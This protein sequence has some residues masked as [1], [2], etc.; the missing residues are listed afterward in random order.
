MTAAPL[1][2]I[3]RGSMPRLLLGAIIGVTLLRTAI[4]VTTGLTDDEAYY[5]LWTLAPALS[6]LDHPP[7]VAWLMSAGRFL[8]GDTVLGLRLPSLLI[9]LAGP[10]LLWRTAI[11]LFDRQTAIAAVAFALVMPLLAVGGIITTPDAPSVLFWGLCAWGL[12]EMHVS[13]NANWWLAVG[14]F[15]GLGLLSKY[16][17]LFVGAGILL[18]VLVVPRN[19]AW[20]K[21]WQLWAGGVIAAICTLPVVIW[22]ARYHWASFDK[23]LGRAARGADWTLNF[24]LEMLGGYIGLASPIIAILGLIGLARL[25]QE[26][27]RSRDERALLVLSGLAPLVLYFLVHALHARVQAN[28]LAPLYPALALA[29]GY[30][31]TLS[32]SA[33]KK[34]WFVAAVATGAV[35]TGLVYLHALR[36]F[37]VLEGPRDPTSQ[38]RGWPQL[39]AEVERLRQQNGAAWIG[40]GNYATTGQLAFA[41][42]QGAPVMQVN[43]R[44]RYVHLPQVDPA[45]AAKPGLVVEIDDRPTEAMLRSRFRSVRP[46]GEVARTYRGVVLGTYALFVVSHPISPATVFSYEPGRD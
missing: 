24:L 39:A 43:D 1:S 35:M 46:A 16:T 11:L 5:R 19:R 27:S 20:L 3:S 30:Q 18:W 25:M 14:F 44:L 2:R 34:R 33:H 23:Q 13:R 31:L 40:T 38:M 12:A 8:A 6:F 15:A 42:R 26:A 4:A 9:S 32:A 7:M 21:S 10:F 22:N 17:N 45:L 29:A 37:L 41:F 36:P 28:W